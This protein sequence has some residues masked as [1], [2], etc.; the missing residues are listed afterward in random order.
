LTPRQSPDQTPAAESV[1]VTG[2]ASP[3]SAGPRRSASPRSARRQWL[4]LSPDSTSRGRLE[5]WSCVVLI[6]S[7]DSA[8]VRRLN[9]VVPR[10]EVSEL[11]TILVERC[12]RIGHERPR[13][14]RSVAAVDVI[15]RGS[16]R[17]GPGQ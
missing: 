5:E 10:E 17:R 8:L 13:P 9:P 15:G 6:G 4:R 16:W 12:G 7:F 11:V 3:V 2:S 1:V 14:L